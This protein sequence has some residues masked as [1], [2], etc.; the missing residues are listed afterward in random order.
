MLGAGKLRTWEEGM[1]SPHEDG[2]A[3]LLVGWGQ[4]LIQAQP[5]K[6][7]S[8]AAQEPV[9]RYGH[10]RGTSGLQQGRRS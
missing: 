2:N 1:D 3:P 5:V 8:A 9:Q 4:H 10:R 6:D 7:H